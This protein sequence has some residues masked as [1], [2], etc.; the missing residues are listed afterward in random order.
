MG[1]EGVQEPM[2]YLVAGAPDD[3]PAR[4]GITWHMNTAL[5]PVDERKKGD[6]LVVEEFV[7]VFDRVFAVE[8][9]P[10]PRP[11]VGR[12][13]IGHALPVAPG[14]VGRIFDS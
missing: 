11:M 5:G 13:V 3:V 6:P 14:E 2:D 1:F 12:L 4:D 8:P 7:N 10:C 9:S